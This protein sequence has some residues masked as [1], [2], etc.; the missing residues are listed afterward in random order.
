MEIKK[1]NSYS[2]IANQINRS[3]TSAFRIFNKKENNTRIF[4]LID[5]KI[6]I[7][8]V[9]FYNNQIIEKNIHNKMDY[10]EFIDFLPLPTFDK[11]LFKKRKNPK[12]NDLINLIN[13]INN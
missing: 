9:F 1:I 10:I 6:N 13:K 12:V 4:D 5:L 7:P 8:I 3:K 11:F 2:F